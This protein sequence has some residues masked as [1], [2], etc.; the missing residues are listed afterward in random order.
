[1]LGTSLQFG[2][3]LGEDECYS[4]VKARKNQKHSPDRSK[5]GAFGNPDSKRKAGGGSENGKPKETPDLMDGP[6]K[7]PSA[8]PRSN[9]ERLLDSTT[10]SVPAQYL[11]K[12]TMRG[13]QACDAKYFVLGDLWES[14]KEWS[15]Y[16]AGVP[17]IL[18]GSDRVVQ[19]YV[20][21]LS[22]I[23]LY[24]PLANS[25]PKSGSGSEDSDSDY[26]KDSSSDGSSDD[27]IEREAKFAHSEDG[28]SFRIGG[29]SVSTDQSSGQE[30]F[31]SDDSEA[32]NSRGRL[33][34]EY[35]ERDP[36]YIREPLADKIMDLAGRFQT[37]K[38]IRSCDLLPFSWISIA[39]YPIYR[40]P[41][42]PTLKDLD[43]CFLMY[44]TLS[45]PMDGNGFIF[46][47]PLQRCLCTAPFAH[48]GFFTGSGRAM[49][50]V[51]K[52]RL[53]VTGM[54]TYKFKGSVWIQTGFQERHR[55]NSLTR[56]ADNWLRLLGVRHP[57][58]E[59]FASHGIYTR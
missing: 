12:T 5:K 48:W 19:Y 7:D 40:I 2:T 24:G 47:F 49:E 52:I 36:P 46:C 38:T 10:P 33:L 4:P 26:Y 39:W 44:H 53:P 6:P 14:F 21:Y 55:V 35:F 27:Y 57:D 1:M 58:F 34:F 43:A 51:P 18:D 17:L 32:G 29:L 9:L 45:T 20:P 41:T 31:S 22:G 42:G 8:G 59:F 30:G 56:D 23:Q 11:P 28:I 50:R 3:V 13:R 37:L 16:G 25:N 15:A 54:A